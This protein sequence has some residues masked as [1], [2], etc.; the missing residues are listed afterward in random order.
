MINSQNNFRVK[1]WQKLKDRHGRA[2]HKR[3][4]V[5]GV[6]LVQEAAKA[7]LLE[8]VI[9]AAGPGSD[10]GFGVPAFAVSPDVMEKL[11][12][13]AQAPR[14]MGVAK[15]PATRS[16][17]G[18]AVFVNAVHHPG[19]LGTI[20]RNAAAFGV[21]TVAADSSADPFCP[22]AAQASQGMLFHVN[23]KKFSPDEQIRQAK[24]LKEQGYAIIGTD[25]GGGSS[26]EEL[27]HG[28]KWGLVLG[29]EKDGVSEEMLAL[30]D[31]SVRIRT[32][33]KCESLN[34][35]VASGILLHWLSRG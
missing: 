32:D 11:T 25:V 14:I 9:C 24:A 31:A 34:V 23:I 3:L 15:M 28:G 18:N 19:N 26:L 7:G 1:Q 20:I 17:S 8:E 12:V 2:K 5:H 21:D 27:R 13:H 10:L 16:I 4:L 6:H 22:K 35:G 33:A 30:C 29:N